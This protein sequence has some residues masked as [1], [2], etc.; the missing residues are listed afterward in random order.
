MAVPTTAEALQE[1]DPDVSSLEQLFDST[2]LKESSVTATSSSSL[3]AEAVAHD[4]TIVVSPPSGCL[5][6]GSPITSRRPYN[7]GKTFIIR[8]DRGGSFHIYPYIGGPFQSL[9]EADSAI[10]RHLDDLRDKNVCLDGMSWTERVTR[11]ALYRPDGTRKKHSKSLLEPERLKH[12]RLLVQALL[13]K[14]NE[15]HNRLGNLAYELKDIVCIQSVCEGSPQKYDWYYHLNFTARTKGDDEFHSGTDNLFF[16]EV[17]RIGG[18]YKDFALS[19]FYMLKP[20]DDGH[21][22][23]CTYN[24]RADLKHPN[25]ADEYSGGHLDPYLPYGGDSGPDENLDPEEEA[26]LQAKEEAR[27]KRIYKCLDDPKF[28]EKMRRRFKDDPR[29]EA[30]FQPQKR[31]DPR[32]GTPLADLQ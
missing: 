12:T 23:G 20:N 13:D 29:A 14:Y 30:F 7:W 18:P 17:T 21:C 26:E 4:D 19:C 9:Q 28:L 25:D 16:A 22:R 10:N 31:R 27:L 5:S 1:P 2:S 6:P 8:I 32:H 3:Q 11:R 15:D 24:K